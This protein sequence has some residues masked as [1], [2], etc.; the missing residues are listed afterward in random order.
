MS[1]QT[2]TR[3]SGV[4]TPDIQMAEQFLFM[5]DPAASIFTFQTF[6]DSKAKRP[7][8]AKIR[9]G[10][11]AA[12]ISALCDANKAGAGIFV[13][14]NQT[15]GKG[16]EI[17]NMIRA[18]AVWCDWDH[19]DRD[20]PEWPLEPSATVAT[21][22]GKFQFLWL[23]DYGETMTPNQHRDVIDSIV[24][25]GGDAGA[26]GYNRV[27]RVPGFYH[28]KN[29]A[30]P[31]MAELREISGNRYAV[32]ELLAAFPPVVAKV[33][34]VHNPLLDSKPEHLRGAT[35]LDIGPAYAPTTRDD[36][37]AMLKHAPLDESYGGWLN[38]GM[39]LHSW[40][41]DAGLEL[42]HE[43][44]RQYGD[45]YNEQE[46]DEKWRT[47]KAKPGGVTIATIARIA[48]DNGYTSPTPRAQGA[49]AADGVQGDSGAV[50][51]PDICGSRP[52]GADNHTD[53][54][55]ARRIKNA[56]GH[57]LCYC[58]AVDWMTHSH[59]WHPDKGKGEQIFHNL[60]RLIR[61]EAKRMD[62]WVNAADPG[63]EFKVREKARNGRNAW[64]MLSESASKI[65]A[66]ITLGRR[67]MDVAANLLDRNLLHVGLKNGVLDLGT[68]AFHSELPAAYVTHA[69]GVEYQPGATCPRWQAFVLEIMGGDTEMAAYL[70]RLAGYILTANRSEHLLLILHGG[71]S[72]GKSTFVGI[73]QKVM[74][75]Y[76]MSLPSEAICGR[77]GMTPTQKAAL[78]GKR[79]G[80]L[81][82]T[83]D[84][85]RLNEAEVKVLTGADSMTGRALYKEDV[86]YTPTHQLLVQTNHRPGI[87]GDD[88]AIWRRIE[89]I[90]F[91]VRFT[92]QTKDRNLPQKLEAELPGILNWMIEGYQQYRAGGLGRPEAIKKAKGAY[93]RDEDL[94]SSWMDERCDTSKSTA[95]IT[96][97]TA[98][99]SFKLWLDDEGIRAAMTKKHFRQRF[100]EAGFPVVLG[101]HD[102]QLAVHGVTLVGSA[103]GWAA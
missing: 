38:I 67:E 58:P 65:N 46:I 30:N 63:D 22:P 62:E 5:L 57:R 95:T 98:Y 59:T 37:A 91:A 7:T 26:K 35:G 20:P 71:G 23:L 87:R 4:S 25:M 53:L 101:G 64:A 15:D 45:K 90:P 49:Q 69:C 51:A 1:T 41:E 77:D 74:G 12:H 50:V 32:D 52:F 10:T 19:A 47:F 99:L 48:R 85:G 40:D 70:Q 16:R 18:R 94:F 55:N 102:K 86:T 97:A 34:N 81:A 66:A 42:W 3:A 43:W 28:M 33:Q 29:P 96:L 80:V 56:Y 60:G 21:S 75:D 92:D 68:G 39:A 13:T 89:L 17:G 78:R 31:Y 11:L 83:R 24:S 88:H 84:G 73:L 100:E 79:L 44:S 82:E 103:P 27:L 36:V 6:D 2:I 54:A 61:D 76:A 72:N 93:R 8:L 14:I 9:H